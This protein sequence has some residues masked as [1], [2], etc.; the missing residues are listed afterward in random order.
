[1]GRAIRVLFLALIA[2]LVAA[3]S[4][5]TFNLPSDT[6]DPTRF[7]GGI[8]DGTPGA[9]TCE[10]CLEDRCCEQVGTCDGTQSCPGT[11]SSVHACVIEAG[12]AGAQQEMT[13]A[14]Q[15]GKAG[16]PPDNAYRCMRGACG[17]ECGLP[18]CKVDPAAL[19]VQTPR[20]DA[21]FA[22]S[23]CN[24]LNA[25]YGNR[26]CKLTLECIINT[27]KTDLGDALLA[28]LPLALPDAGDANMFDACATVGA[29]N[30]LGPE[31]PTCVRSCLC[32]YKENDQGLMPL[33]P[34]LRPAMLSLAVYECGIRAGCG[35]SCPTK[36]GGSD[37]ARDAAADAGGDAP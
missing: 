9:S 2:S 4:C 34:A 28:G 31:V 15:L 10:R 33:D 3:F 30:G 6:C 25:C 29:R 19:I 16:D 5:K 27:C 11:V 12:L 21:C 23:C 1:M 18:V 22:S 8:A 36:D 20:C 37:A 32:A 17:N 26:A 14:G 13:C 24:E 7:H 35:R